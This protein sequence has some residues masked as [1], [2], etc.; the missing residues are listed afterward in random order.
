[1]TRAL[2][3]KQNSEKG[4]IVYGDG[5]PEYMVPALEQFISIF[6]YEKAMKILYKQEIFYLPRIYFN[7]DR[8][9]VEQFTIRP[10]KNFFELEKSNKNKAYNPSEVLVSYIYRI[11]P[12]YVIIINKNNEAKEKKKLNFKNLLYYKRKIIDHLF[13]IAS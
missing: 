9:N 6:G 13:Q 10:L 2:L 1:M 4:V 11:Y 5:Y 12:T 7:T 3:F 8:I